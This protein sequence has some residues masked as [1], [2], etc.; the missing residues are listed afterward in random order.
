MLRS[1]AMRLAVLSDIHGNLP[2]LEAVIDHAER[3]SVDGFV[4][5]GDI[6]IGAPDSLA[7]WER[8][9]ALNCPVLRGNHEMYA[10]SFYENATWQTPQFAPVAW[11]VKQLDDNVR[12]ELGTLPFSLT[13]PDAPDLLFVHASLR[14]DRDNLGA[15]TA[16]AVLS[17]MF[18]ALSARYVVRGHDHVAATRTWGE[19]QL[20]TNGSVGIPLNAVT[21]AQYLV[22]ERHLDEW[23]P[24]FYSVTYDVDKTLKRFYE[25]DY[26]EAAS[27]MAHFFYR[28]IAT[29]T[30]QL[31]PFWRNYQRYSQDGALSLE[32]AVR[33]F[34][35]FGSP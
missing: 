5:I 7:C 33:A 35:R 26:L 23:Q 32:E 1:L 28:E 14:N 34:L 9:K 12:R 11:A 18:P 10:A 4:V 27:P 21:E 29:A 19:H 22:L 2:A 3:L 30:S 6:V 20:I 17:E 25:T 24:T 15:Y 13:L 16:E 31:L 8:V